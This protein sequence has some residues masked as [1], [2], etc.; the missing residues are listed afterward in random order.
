M[1]KA[2]SPRN[3]TLIPS[4]THQT[5]P[6][7]PASMPV[8]NS[9]A[10]PPRRALNP[11]KATPAR[12]AVNCG[13]P[14]ASM[15]AGVQVSWG[16]LQGTRRIPP[17]GTAYQLQAQGFHTAMGQMVQ[18]HWMG[19]CDKE[20]RYREG[21]SL[22]LGVIMTPGSDEYRDIGLSCPESTAWLYLC[23]PS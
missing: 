1:A 13:V 19:Q 11:K 2:L 5:A 22:Y 3:K 10:I 4:K 9:S 21:K 15:R 23:P 14:A 18:C 6:K 16:Q 20:A 8:G 12:V 17:S 7:S